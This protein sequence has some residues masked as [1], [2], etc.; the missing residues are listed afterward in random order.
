MADSANVV[1]IGLD[2]SSSVIGIAIKDEN[3]IT[4][5][6]INLKKFPDLF[7]KAK[8]IEENFYSYFPSEC[9]EIYVEDYAKKFTA[10]MSSA[11]TITVLSSINFL[12][13]YLLYRNYESKPKYINVSTARKMLAIKTASKGATPSEKKRFI[14]NQMKDRHKDVNWLIKTNGDYHSVNYDMADALIIL[15]SQA[16]GRTNKS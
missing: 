10:G 12:M 7:E 5:N 6:H 11:S 4:L 8:H 3:G 2:I 1:Q 14:F 9:D 15:E 16:L 13:C